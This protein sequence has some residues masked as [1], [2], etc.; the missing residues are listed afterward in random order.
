MK[1]GAGGASSGTDGSAAPSGD[2]AG[3]SP[4]LAHNVVW[5]LAFPLNGVS[6]FVLLRRFVADT[7]AAFAGS[8]VF[9]FSFYVML[10]AGGHLHLIWLWPLPLSLVLFER[11]DLR[12]TG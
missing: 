4:V 12:Q 6:A 11:R 2:A 10:H 3:A 1:S 8:L 7:T 5:V 9:A